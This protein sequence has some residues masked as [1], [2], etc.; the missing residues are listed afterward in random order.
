[1]RGFVLLLDFL[2]YAGG[3]EHLKEFASA[4]QLLDYL[5]DELADYQEEHR[6]ITDRDVRSMENALVRLLHGR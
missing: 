4:N 6:W 3:A 2:E 1:M 5:M